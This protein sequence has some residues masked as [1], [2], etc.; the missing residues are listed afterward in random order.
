MPK[1]DIKSVP[2][3]KG[4]SYPAPFH[5]QA[6]ER[7]RQRL[8]D[9]GGLSDFGVNLMRLPPGAWSSQRHWHSGEDEF[10]CVL[11]GEVVLVTDK[12]EETLK[13]GDCAAF[14]KGVP[15]GHHLVNKSSDA[16]LVLEVGT[17]SDVDV[18][19][20]SDI[21]MKI[22]A[23]DNVYTHKNGTPYPKRGE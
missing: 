22:D 20:Y 1:I 16:A 15:D 3:R 19:T 4:S 14:A 17:R 7:V 12:G 21:D 9:A 10:I 23:R 8:G 5:L 6:G 13:R 11:E 18:C 2:E